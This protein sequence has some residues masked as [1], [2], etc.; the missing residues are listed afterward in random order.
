MKK[1][2]GEAISSSE[3]EHQA[4]NTAISAAK[5][6][7]NHILHYWPNPF[8][9]RFDRSLVMEI[10]EKSEGVGNYA[11]IADKESEKI[12]KAKILRHSLL[13]SHRVIGEETEE[14]V[15]NSEYQWAID[16]IDGTLNFRN[17][18]PN[19]GI[20]IGLLKN[21]EPILGV[22]AFPALEHQPIIAAQKG[23]GAQLL[24]FTGGEFANLVEVQQQ[25]QP[26]DK[27]LIAY[28]EGYE[29]RAR[30]IQKYAIPLADKVAYPVSYASSAYANYLVAL[31]H[32]GAYIHET[33]TLFDIAAPGAIIP[34]IG[35]VITD[36]KG[37]P[38]D[39]SAS[40]RSYLA[41]RDPQL[42]QQILELLGR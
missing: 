21:N 38:I 31:G 12:I 29:E 15:S 41:A 19:F 7:G 30:Q 39:W 10:F 2:T 28:D 20:S 33:P 3:I 26:I 1:E 23:K 4:Y 34:E 35:G 22:M 9:R 18:L 36:I 32:V 11:T 5:D 42:H 25:A 27:T 40:S 17:G 24:T 8:N 14:V 16:P 13:S 37:N 6:A